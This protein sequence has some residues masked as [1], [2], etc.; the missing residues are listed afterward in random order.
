MARHLL[1]HKGLTSAGRT[2]K[3]GLS[4]AL[5]NLHP[6]RHHFFIQI[7]RRRHLRQRIRLGGGVPHAHVLRR[8]NH[9][10]PERIE[11]QLLIGRLPVGVPS[12][13]LALRRR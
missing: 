1:G 9:L 11:G 12:R 10:R 5:H 8:R 7:D 6:A 4:L 13:A 2:I 3:N